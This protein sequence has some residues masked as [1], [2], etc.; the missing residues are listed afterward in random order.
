VSRFNADGRPR[1]SLAGQ[2]FLG[3]WDRQPLS[4]LFDKIQNTMPADAPRTLTRPQV[5]DVVTRPQANQF[6]A[7]GVR[8]D[9]GDAALR[10][11]ALAS[12]VPAGSPAGP[13]YRSPRLAT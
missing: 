8:L 13:A 6:P 4:D 1:T 3:I 12:A 10:R 11:I 7:G 9:V 2:A 5:A